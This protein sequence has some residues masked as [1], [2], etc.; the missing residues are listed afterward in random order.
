[1]T[2]Y[3]T[4]GSFYGGEPPTAQI[5]ELSADTVELGES[6]TIYG[7][8]FLPGTTVTIQPGGVVIGTSSPVNTTEI[9][10]TLPINLPNIKHIITVSNGTS[11]SAT[12]IFVTRA[13]TF[14]N[15]SGQSLDV[16]LGELN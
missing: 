4:P 13:V 6:F 2:W 14:T 11:S 8:G 12:E 10:A 1:M 7:S 5:T 9:T 16:L 15:T 3:I